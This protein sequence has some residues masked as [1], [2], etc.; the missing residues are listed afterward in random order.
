MEDGILVRVHESYRLVVAVC[1]KDVFGEKLVE[2]NRVL[3]LSGRFFDGEEMNEEEASLKI[4][5]CVDEDA[6]FNI[7]GSKSIE[8]AKRLGVVKDEGVMMIQG[9]PFALVL[10]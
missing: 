8:L 1:D 5:R 10:L 9:V 3:D 2:G 7:V 6:T 4:S